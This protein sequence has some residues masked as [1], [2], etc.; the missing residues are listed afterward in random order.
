MFYSSLESSLSITSVNEELIL[1]EKKASKAEKERVAL[2][3][4]GEKHYG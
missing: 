3:S 2:Q 1:E 4:I